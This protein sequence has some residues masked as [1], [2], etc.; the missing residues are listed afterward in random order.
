MGVDCFTINQL[1]TKYIDTAK[2]I[3][4]GQS[5]NNS[6]ASLR[7]RW[8]S[9]PQFFAFFGDLFE[10]RGAGG[11]RYVTDA[12]QTFSPGCRNIV[13]RT[14]SFIRSISTKNSSSWKWICWTIYAGLRTLSGETCNPCI[15]RWKA[16]C[17]QG[18][19]WNKESA[20]H[21]DKHWR[22]NDPKALVFHAPFF[23]LRHDD[24]PFATF[25]LTIKRVYARDKKG[26]LSWWKRSHLTRVNWYN[27]T[28]AVKKENQRAWK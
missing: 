5:G 9:F 17:A 12:P 25:A 3:N 16:D 28:R 18:V 14:L 24:F 10:S 23:V 21:Y 11:S 19:F 15:A 1:R 26:L 27:G 8:A 13:K 2:L 22:N 6:T 4:K 20:L 7:R